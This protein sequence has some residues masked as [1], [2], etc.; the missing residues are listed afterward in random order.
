M[1]ILVIGSGGREHALCWKLAQSPG[2]E[3]M[4][5]PGNPGMAQVARCL[6]LAEAEELSPDLTVVGPEAPLVDGI[7]DRYR[8]RGLRI[9]GPTAEAARLEGSKIFAKH[10]LQQSGIPTARWVTVENRDD[11]RRALRQFDYPVVL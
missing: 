5:A 3:L 4:A 6:P 1:K 2:V 8:A 7:V 9:V 10:F 11:A